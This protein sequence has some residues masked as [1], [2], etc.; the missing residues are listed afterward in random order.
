MV[1]HPIRLDAKGQL[2]R[3]AVS[4]SKGRSARRPNRIECIRLSLLL[5]HVAPNGGAFDRRSGGMS[6][7]RTRHLRRGRIALRACEWPSS[8]R[9]AEHSGRS[10]THMPLYRAAVDERLIPGGIDALAYVPHVLT[11][12][13]YCGS[14]FTVPASH[15]AHSHTDKTRR[16]TAPLIAQRHAHCNTSS[17]AALARPCPSSP[18][19]AGGP[20]RIERVV[21]CRV[22]SPSA[23]RHVVHQRARGA[24]GE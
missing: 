14:D 7:R 9:A 12:T 5:G 13:L 24:A 22:A 17:P 2:G 1:V 20:V 21:I 10:R 16:R 23:Q 4:D 8:L 11:V 19:S 6:L 18:P 3:A 15:S